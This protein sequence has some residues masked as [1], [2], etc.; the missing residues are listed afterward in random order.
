MKGFFLKPDLSVYFI[1]MPLIGIYIKADYDKAKTFDDL[2]QLVWL[3]FEISEKTTN[4]V[5]AKW[6]YTAASCLYQILTG[7]SYESQI[8]IN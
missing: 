6:Y 4:E 8:N 2:V 7:R 5:K 1:A 3:W